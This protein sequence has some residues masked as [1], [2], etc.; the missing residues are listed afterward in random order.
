MMAAEKTRVAMMAA[1]GI[2]LEQMKKTLEVKLRRKEAANWQISFRSVRY[3]SIR[4][5]NYR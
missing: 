3:Q 5:L 4:I 2:T 1:A